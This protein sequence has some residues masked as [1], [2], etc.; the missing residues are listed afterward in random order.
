MPEKSMERESFDGSKNENAPQELPWFE[1]DDKKLSLLDLVGES[2]EQ[3]R[4]GDKIRLTDRPGKT[5]FSVETSEPSEFP[6]TKDL[7]EELSTTV[8]GRVKGHY[9]ANDK[10]SDD[11]R[12]ERD[13]QIKA[14]QEWMEKTAFEVGVGVAIALSLPEMPATLGGIVAG[15]VLS[16]IIRQG[17]GALLGE[18][19]NLS[20]TLNGDLGAA[21]DLATGIF[22]DCVTGKFVTCP[23]TSSVLGTARGE[24]IGK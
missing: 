19:N 1:K 5:G 23:V 11:L 20:K 14:N 24:L 12:E 18:Q 10:H 15:S 8:I 4:P 7:F 13:K 6:R 3:A 21:V 17:G 9:D 22:L 2:H 16:G